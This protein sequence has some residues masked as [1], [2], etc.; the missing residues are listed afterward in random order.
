M[1]AQEQYAAVRYVFYAYIN[2]IYITN[3]VASHE[4][5]MVLWKQTHSNLL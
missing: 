5:P 1:I 4:I 2:I 3:L